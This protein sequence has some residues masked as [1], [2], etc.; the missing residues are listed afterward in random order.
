MYSIGSEEIHIVHNQVMATINLFMMREKRGQS[1]QNFQ[2]QFTAMRQV[3]DQLGLWI[4]QSFQGAWVILNQ[5]AVLLKTLSNVCGRQYDLQ[6]QY[7]K[8]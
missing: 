2:E 3:C 8:R 4:G 7:Y 5:Q 1:P 6:L